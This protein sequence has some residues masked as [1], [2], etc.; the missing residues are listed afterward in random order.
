MIHPIFS[1]YDSKV[2]VFSSPFPQPNSAVAIR[3]FA[4]AANT[5]GNDLYNYPTDFSLF[6]IGLFDDETGHLSSISHVNHGPA[7]QYKNQEAK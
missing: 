6:Q 7:S 3:A 1:V 5:V 2:S 4:L